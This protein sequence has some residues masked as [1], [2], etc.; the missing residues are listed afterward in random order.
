M[1]S[2][3]SFAIA[4]LLM[5]GGCA[6]VPHDAGIADISH[7]V[8]ERTNQNVE[9]Q[10]TATMADDSRVAAM[11][12]QPLDADRAVA[13]AMVNNPRLQIILADLGVA[14]AELIEASTIPNPI[15]GGEIRAPGGPFKPFELS[16]T[17]SLI[18]LISLPRRRQLGAARFEAS[19][20]RISAEV[21]RF[22][23]EVREQYYKLVAASQNLAMSRTISQTTR[24]STELAIRQH[25]AGNITD[26]DLEREQAVYE[27]SKLELAQSEAEVVLMREA[28][29][30]ALGLRDASRN[31]S[32]EEQFPQPPQQE[33]SDQEIDALAQTRRLDIVLAQREV[34]AAQRALPLAR[35]SSI[36]DVVAGVHR[37]REPEGKV[38]TGPALE[39]PIPIFNRGRGARLRAEA[40][41]LRARQRLALLTSAASSE[42]R[43]ARQHLAA[44]RARV[45]YYRDVLL[46]RRVRIVELMKLEQNS[47]LAG[48]FQVLQARQDEVHAR[49]EYIDAQR[50]YWM[51]R[52]DLDRALNGTTPIDSMMESGTTGS[53]E[54]RTGDGGRRRGGH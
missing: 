16:L 42:I 47:M 37:E 49:R 48:I 3:P 30:R 51:A 19:K 7:T 22:A 46:P 40:E 29:I 38:T 43:A 6:S 18:D 25:A 54:R 52:N 21:V 14:R 15:I 36:G 26:L 45:E 8:R 28:L 4:G 2:Q 11:L 23:A 41:L 33:L 17:Q 32:I 50:Q 44:S 31:W 27:E 1:K 12:D 13:L 20:A 5:L 53:D 24:T 10:S 34:E 9:W 35:R 39:L